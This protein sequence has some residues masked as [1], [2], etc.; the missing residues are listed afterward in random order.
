VTE[1]FGQQDLRE[2]DSR[3]ACLISCSKP[4]CSCWLIRVLNPLQTLDEL[5]RGQTGRVGVVPFAAIWAQVSV[6]GSCKSVLPW[7]GAWAPVPCLSQSSLR[8]EWC[9]GLPFAC[10]GFLRGLP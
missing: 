2:R 4:H 3:S 6:P 8:G 5:E 7:G 1:I 10:W 9:E